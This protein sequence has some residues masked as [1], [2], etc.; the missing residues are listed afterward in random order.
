MN[1][2]YPMK[3]NEKATVCYKNTCATVE[4]ETARLVNVM[5]G[6]ATLL[7]ILVML[8]KLSKSL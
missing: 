5:V 2:F 8:N 4:G 6:I 3:T 7:G 1:N